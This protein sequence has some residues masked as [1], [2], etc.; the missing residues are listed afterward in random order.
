RFGPPIETIPGSSTDAIKDAFGLTYPNWSVTL[1]LDIP[2]NSFVSR[3]AYAQAQVN[4]EQSMLQLKNQEQQIYLEIKNTVRAVQTDYKRVQ[5]YKIARELAKKKLTAEEERFRVGLTTP[6]FVLQ[7][8]TE[9]STAQS[10]ELNAIIA[11][12]LSL[13][14]LNRATGVSL[15]EKNI[16]FTEILEK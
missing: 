11:Y 6:Y 5:A 12:N 4:L 8:Q 9:L 13:A 1:T 16:R 3:A 10:N 7:Y 15:K 2:L 14:R